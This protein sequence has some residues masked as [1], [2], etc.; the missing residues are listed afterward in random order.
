MVT[1]QDTHQH[2]LSVK[3]ALNL[4]IGT[5]SQRIQPFQ[6]LKVVYGIHIPSSKAGE[7]IEKGSMERKR[8]MAKP[9]KEAKKF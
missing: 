8:F 3:M 2:K 6:N 1:I 9:E 4:S 7:K 5:L